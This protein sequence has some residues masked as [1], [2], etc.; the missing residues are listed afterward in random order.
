MSIL[1]DMGTHLA[2]NSI[3][4]GAT[5]WTL[6]KSYQPA[7]PDKVL[8]IYETGGPAPDQ[9]Q[10]T[11][12]DFP[13]FQVRGRGEEFGYEA[14]RTKM[15]EV[16]DSLNDAAISGYVY[17]FAAESAPIPI[18]YDKNSNR[19]VLVWNFKAMKARS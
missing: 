14:L 6:A 8:T 16:F 18:G 11:G 3:V 5:G 9:T 15:Q 10:G 4:S 19:P 12:H 1:D 17:I 2:D 7:T 13:T